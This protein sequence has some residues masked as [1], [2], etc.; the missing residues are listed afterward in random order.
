MTARLVTE[1]KRRL[2]ERHRPHWTSTWIWLSF[3]TAFFLLEG[4]LLLILI[5]GPTWV[6]VPLL[7]LLAHLMHC[8]LLA[9]HEAAHGT[10]CPSPALN[11]AI[12]ILIGAF[13]YMSL[14]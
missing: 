5:R 3:A 2:S 14:S 4:L 13:S 6:A 8:H 7:L 10:L 12:G 9:F 1:E 11:D